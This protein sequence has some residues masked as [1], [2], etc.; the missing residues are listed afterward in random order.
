MLECFSCLFERK[1][2]KEN[3]KCEKKGRKREKKSELLPFP[4]DF[5]FYLI[6]V[7][8]NVEKRKKLNKGA[9]CFF[10]LLF[11]RSFARKEE[12]KSGEIMEERDRGREKKASYLFMFSF[13]FHYL[14]H[15]CLI[16]IL[17][18]KREEKKQH[19]TRD[20]V[21]VSFVISVRSFL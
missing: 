13:H 16:S 11:I 21:F 2:R 18:Q 1:Q 10:L 15:F 6:Y 14:F 3:K 20:A 8:R 12:T 7:L 17:Q 9:V 5:F 4:F 19:H